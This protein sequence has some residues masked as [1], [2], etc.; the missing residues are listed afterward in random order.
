MSTYR[1]FAIQGILAAMQSVLIVCGCMMTV[2]ML[3]AMGYPER[4]TEL[5]V[6]ML[7]IRN[8]GFLMILNPLAWVIVTIWL[9]RNQAAWFSKRWTVGTGIAVFLCLGWYLIGSVG[10]AGSR[11]IQ[12]VE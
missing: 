2:A 8:W 11:I 6:K 1:E 5:P 7:F 9:E 3:K 10:Q 12:S 4:F